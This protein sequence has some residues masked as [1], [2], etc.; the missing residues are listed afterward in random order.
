M[1]NKLSQV[2]RTYRTNALWHSGEELWKRRSRLLSTF[3][4]APSNASPV[5]RN[6][7]DPFALFAA[8]ELSRVLSAAGQVK[9]SA[10]SLTHESKAEPDLEADADSSLATNEK[11]TTFQQQQVVELVQSYNNLHNAIASTSR[12]ISSKTIQKALGDLSSV[13]LEQLGI[14]QMNDGIL[15][16]ND[17]SDQDQLDLTKTGDFATILSSAAS[18]L[19]ALPPEQFIDKGQPPFK[20]I[21]NYSFR[22]W[23]RSQVNT[24]LPIPLTGILLNQYL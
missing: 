19:L 1:L 3:S 22:Q 17:L 6:D 8:Q 11:K 4:S 24:Y 21:T 15:Q 9:D 20:S 2:A 13:P 10:Q 23:E 18:R 5:V 7:F 16:M 14:R 12:S